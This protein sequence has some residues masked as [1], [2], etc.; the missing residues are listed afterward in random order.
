MARLDVHVDAAVGR[1]GRR[2]GH[3]LDFARNRDDQPRAPVQQHVPHRQAPPFRTPEEVRVVRE[4][5]LRLRDADREEARLFIRLICLKL[6]KRERLKINS[7]A[8]VDFLNLLVTAV[9]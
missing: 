4:R 9:C 8:A 7:I 2:A 5:I 1:R 6:F 3:Q